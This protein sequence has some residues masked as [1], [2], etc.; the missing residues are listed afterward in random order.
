MVSLQFSW[1]RV[2]A[3]I[4]IIYV[5]IVAI[6]SAVAFK[7]IRDHDTTEGDDFNNGSSSC[8]GNQTGSSYYD[9]GSMNTRYWLNVVSAILLTLVAIAMWVGN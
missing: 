3:F 4:I 8:S 1:A 6:M 5:F 7:N 2:V 9:Y